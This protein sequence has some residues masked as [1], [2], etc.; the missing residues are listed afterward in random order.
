[1]N[2]TVKILLVC[3][4]LAGCAAPSPT[5][6][7]EGVVCVSTL[8]TTVVTIGRTTGPMTITPDCAVHIE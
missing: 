6:M 8:T 5:V 1:M 3:A 7:P 4:P 2:A